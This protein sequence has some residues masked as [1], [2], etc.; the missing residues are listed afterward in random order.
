MGQKVRITNATTYL[1]AAC[2]AIAKAE[3]KTSNASICPHGMRGEY[4][5][6]SQFVEYRPWLEAKSR[7]ALYYDDH[8]Q[9]E[10]SRGNVGNI[11]GRRGKFV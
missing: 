7:S 9:L 6:P 8:R 5:G 11:P 4:G 1:S 10:R 2:G 3:F